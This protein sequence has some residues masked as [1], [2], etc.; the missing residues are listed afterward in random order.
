M[1]LTLNNINH[2]THSKLSL[3]NHDTH[4]KLTFIN[5]DTHSKLSQQH[6]NKYLDNPSEI[7]SKVGIWSY[8]LS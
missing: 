1:T 4:S 2:D 5:H 8:T 3:I 6:N 7:I